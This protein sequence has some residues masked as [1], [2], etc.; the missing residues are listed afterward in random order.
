MVTLVEGHRD[1]NGV[2]PVCKV[3]P[4]APSTCYEYKAREA[5]PVKLPARLR[6]DLELRERVGR[7]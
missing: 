1:A 7:I 5:D 6:R 4:I 3:V 2:E